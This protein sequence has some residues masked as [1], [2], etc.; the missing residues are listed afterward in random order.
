MPV[1]NR[2]TNTNI[3]WNI[4]QD[5]DNYTLPITNDNDNNKSSSSPTS[6]TP[7]LT[8][9]STTVSS[10]YGQW[11]TKFINFLKK[12]QQSTT[13]NN[14]TINTPL[15][16]TG[17]KITLSYPHL[18]VDSNQWT[19]RT[20]LGICLLFSFTL[21]IVLFSFT[22]TSP[23]IT[24]N[25]YD[26]NV[27]NTILFT[28]LGIRK[29]KPNNKPCTIAEQ[30]EYQLFIE[31]YIN[32]LHIMDT[33]ENNN[34]NNNN[35]LYYND[36][37]N[38]LLQLYNYR[39]N[40]IPRVISIEEN[41][42]Q[43]PRKLHSILQNQLLMNPLIIHIGSIDTKLIQKI[44]TLYLLSNSPDNIQQN[45]NIPKSNWEYITI[46]L[47]TSSNSALSLPSSLSSS[48]TNIVQPPLEFSTETINNHIQKTWH[49]YN[50]NQYN[51]IF[52]FDRWIQKHNYIKFI[53]TTIAYSNYGIGNT[54]ISN[55]H[56]HIFT[57]T[58]RKG[59][60]P[61]II[62]N[63]PLLFE[64]G[65]IQ[66]LLFEYTEYW[67][68][69]QGYTL[70]DIITKLTIYYYK[71]Y[72]ITPDGLVNYNNLNEKIS[73]KYINSHFFC[74]R[75]EDTDNILYDINNKPTLL[76]SLY[77]PQL[78]LAS[79]SIS[80]TGSLTNIITYYNQKSVSTYPLFSSSVCSNYY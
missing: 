41:N 48:L 73:S 18:Y 38:I 68:N 39:Y 78:S 14:V 35:R 70:S 24:K 63:S 47:S 72:L 31:T 53:N 66:Y 40:Y 23:F 19:I 29:L 62:M 2:N 10:F 45:N 8:T 50:I 34:N 33:T 5:N 49:N 42:N 58:S 32:A 13:T 77:R 26:N 16:T 30:T 12:S 74:G 3:G 22:S 79:S 36:I 55:R 59:L 80:V 56:I 6:S 65:I 61:L 20:Y 1:I 71:C 69:K 4:N 7:L 9:L 27:Y 11:N 15:S 64:Q 25:K 52:N 43:Y 21:S 67:T 28:N 60:E 75:Q 57:I 51:D 44:I 76:P 54:L 17:N 46:S 37:D